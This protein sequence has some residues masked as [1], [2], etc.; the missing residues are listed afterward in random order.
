MVGTDKL[1]KS[2]LIADTDVL[3][4]QPFLYIN[5]TARE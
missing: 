1:A 3:Y 5:T 4:S 2:A